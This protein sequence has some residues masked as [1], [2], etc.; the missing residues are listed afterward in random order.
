LYEAAAVDGASAW[1]RF[2]DITVPQ[3]RSVLFV[4]IL[5]RAIWDFREFDLIFLLTGGGPL[6]S[7]T[8]LP[9]LV[10]KE[11]FE[12]FRMGRALAISV[13]MLLVMM[14]FIASYFQ[15]LRRSNAMNERA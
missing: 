13:V 6:G 3:L 8:T 1:S 2:W 7:T 4:V 12:T 9:L 14:V 5:L 15:L 10:Y 11:A